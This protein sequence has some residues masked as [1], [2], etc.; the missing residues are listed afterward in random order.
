MTFPPHLSPRVILMAGAVGAVVMAFAGYQ[1]GRPPDRLQ[2]SLPAESPVEVQR[3]LTAVRTLPADE[4]R[5]GEPPTPQPAQTPD[6]QRN[7]RSEAPVI[8]GN[9]ERPAPEQLQAE[10]EILAK[11]AAR[12]RVVHP[13]SATP[14]W[15]L[16]LRAVNNGTLDVP[17]PMQAVI[18]QL[19]EQ[20]VKEVGGPDQN[21]ADPAYAER[22]LTA[23]QRADD[24]LRAQIGWEAFNAYSLATPHV[25]AA[26]Q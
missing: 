14:T 3:K 26:K 8:P 10:V 1:L 4:I 18:Q 12:E 24:L 15:P 9:G 21:P 22:W 6:L 5:A 20:F 19:Q 25:N 13:L 17:P 7:G 23:T 11:P 2:I 16:A